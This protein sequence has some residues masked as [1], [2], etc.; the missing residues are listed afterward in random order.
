MEAGD[1]QIGSL[2]ASDCSSNMGMVVSSCP[3]TN[4]DGCCKTGPTEECYYGAFGGQTVQ[5]LQA[6][7]TG[8]WSTTP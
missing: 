5:Q 2:T 6:N 1:C 4:L 7:C 8:T 3:T